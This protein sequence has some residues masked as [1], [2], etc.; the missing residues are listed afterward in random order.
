MVGRAFHSV[1]FEVL[2]E[3]GFVGLGL[4]LSMLLI[5]F[6]NLHAVDRISENKPDLAW[7]R[8]LSFCLKTSMVT[9][10]AAGAFIGIAFLP[11]H[12]YLISLSIAL[13]EYVRRATAPKAVVFVDGRHTPGAAASQP[14]MR[15]G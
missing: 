1:Y 7:C 9:F 10:M 4:F 15:Q 8:D 3:Q 5:F 14:V 13:R 11:Y 2:G 6:W 12:Y